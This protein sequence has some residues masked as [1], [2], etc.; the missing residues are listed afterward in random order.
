LVATLQITTLSILFS[1]KW[2]NHQRTIF[3]RYPA[4]D[5]PKFYVQS[6]DVVSLKFAFDRVVAMSGFTILVVFFI[7][8]IPLNK[9]S[10]LVMILS[11]VQ[12][13]PWIL[14]GYWEKKRRDLMA[15]YAMISKRKAA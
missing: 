10:N 9:L 2:A 8:S 6:V 12:L 4:A 3:K 1:Q 5:Y 7:Y 15:N 11:S 14:V 13:L